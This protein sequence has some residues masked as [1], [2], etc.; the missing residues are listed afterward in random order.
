MY[1][2]LKHIMF[3]IKNTFLTYIESIFFK[4]FLYRSAYGSVRSYGTEQYK[5]N[6][7]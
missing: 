7:F 5:P 1:N 6:S 4:P 2:T 3:I